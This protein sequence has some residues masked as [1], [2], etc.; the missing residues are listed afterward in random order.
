[1]TLTTR[2]LL[3]F[4]GALAVVLAGFSA[5]VYL[6]TR[7]HLYGRAADRLESAARTLAAAVEISPDGA[8]W[9][10]GQRLL[11]FGPGGESVVWQVSDGKGRTVDGSPGA[12]ARLGELGTGGWES[13]YRDT[14]RRDRTDSQ[15]QPWWATRERVR[16]ATLQPGGPGTGKHAEL[17]VTATV[18]L[19]PV[20]DTLYRLALVLAGLSG[21]ILLAALGAGYVICRRALAPVTRMATAA[22]NMGAADFGE[23]LPVAPINDELADLG[24]SFNGLLDRLQES[25][26]RQRRFTGEASHQLRT[27]LAAILGQAE[28]ALRRDR[29]AGEYRD[30]L[31][32]VRGQAAHLG[33]IVDALLFLA[34]VD[35]E[36]GP[37]TAERIDLAAWLPEHLKAWAN[38]P[39]SADIRAE[40]MADGPAW[41]HAHPALLGELVNNLLDN[42][43]KY[44]DPGTPVTVRLGRDAR[45]V[46]V[47]VEDRGCGIAAADR[48]GL[49][50][51]FFRAADARRRGVAGVGLGLAVAA[52]LAKAFGGDIAVTSEPGRGS[53]FRVTLPAA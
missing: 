49:F 23:R 16:P 5:G 26:E 12:D 21:G 40:G 45:A 47:A 8:E 18:P 34:R 50:R 48:D 27:P 28:V 25:F 24:R 44:S 33:R 14:F 32:A 1:V 4:L 29:E 19:G 10:P 52:R 41:V 3:F 30:A 2:L 42:A 31:E 37:P 43:L 36:A 15:G 11:D 38:H 46:T 51:P 53:C 35:A 13:V 22:R 7:D 9:E 6:L 20:R 17:I 39:R